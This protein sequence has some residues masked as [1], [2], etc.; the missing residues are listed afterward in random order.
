MRRE[1]IRS[2][3][4]STVTQHYLRRRAPHAAAA[5]AA[6]ATSIHS[7]HST[8]Y[9]VRFPIAVACLHRYILSSAA[10][11]LLLINLCSAFIAI[12]APLNALKK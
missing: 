3:K 8:I 9:I 10:F 6:A 11:V 5:A 2:V 1:Q 4:P 7:D 12:F